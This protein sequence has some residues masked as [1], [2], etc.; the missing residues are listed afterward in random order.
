MPRV[1][2]YEQQVRTNALPGVRQNINTTEAD[3]GGLSALTMKQSG[4]KLG[5]ISDTMHARAVERMKEDNE[6]AVMDAYTRLSTQEREYMY[7]E[8]GVMTQKG[9]NALGATSRSAKDVGSFAE[10][11]SGEL[12]NE[13]QRASFKKLY[14]RRLESTLDGVSRHEA[15]ERKT[16]QDGVSTGLLKNLAADAETRWN[17]PVYIG[18]SADMA[19]TVLAGKLRKDGVAEELIKFETDTMR[20]GV[21]KSAVEKAIQYDPMKAEQILKDNRKNLSADDAADLEKALK[22]PLANAKGGAIA[23]EA[24]APAGGGGLPAPV[25]SLIAQQAMTQ[26]VNPKLAMTI[27]RLENAKGDPNA[28]PIGKDG[29]PMS[30]AVGIYQFID[31]TWK[32]AGGTAADRLDMN[33]Q[34]ELG[35]KHIKT[36]TDALRTHLG[37]E[38]TE[39]EVYLAHQQGLSGAKALLSAAPGT[40]AAIA[41]APAYKGNIARAGDAINNN[42]GNSSMS[43]EQFVARWNDKYNKMSGRMGIENM[44]L[45][46][47]IE[48]AKARA[49]GDEEV[50]KVAVAKVTELHKQAKEAKKEKVD[51]LTERYYGLMNQGVPDPIKEFTPQELE[52]LGPKTIYELQGKGR[53]VKTDWAFYND[54]MAMSPAQKAEVPLTELMTK[55]GTSEVKTAINERNGSKKGGSKEPWLETR[56]TILKNYSIEMG[57]LPEK[58]SKIKDDDK[59]AYNMLSEYMN[60]KMGAYRTKHGF[61]MPED[62]F[63]KEAGMA[64]TRVVTEKGTLFDTKKRVFE[65]RG[66]QPITIKKIADVPSALRSDIEMR[67]VQGGYKINEALV[68]SLALAKLTNDGARMKAIL[69]GAKKK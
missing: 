14:Q 69:D 68:M 2:E 45:S 8:N 62:E 65:L 34:V 53:N 39:A 10:K 24:F 43:A 31:E 15:S 40:A 58:T 44:S 47:A 49:G 46:D 54:Y 23:A 50:Q 59:L 66:E 7:G 12:K 20:S 36:N 21:W 5:K 17:D 32:D 30:S 22:V 42:G 29:K 1:P 26:G 35:I 28:R 6:V 18:G 51:T 4:E 33:K 57:V 27:A 48:Y 61:E 56:A 55:L 38:P 9:A 63:R 37:R 60:Q 52:I 64:L 67:L 11:I 19:A 25:T 3:F 16:Y 41:L 13:D